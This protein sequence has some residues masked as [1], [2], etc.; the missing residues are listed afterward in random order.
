[1]SSWHKVG[2]VLGL[3]CDLDAGTMQVTVDGSF[4]GRNGGTPFKKGVHPGPKVGSGLFPAVTGGKCQIKCN[5]G[6]DLLRN[7]FRFSAPSTDYI[8]LSI[9]A[10]SLLTQGKVSVLRSVCNGYRSRP[11]ICLNMLFLKC[12]K[13]AC[14]S[15]LRIPT[16]LSHS[17]AWSLSL[18]AVPC[19]SLAFSVSSKQSELWFLCCGF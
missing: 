17:R 1:M 13:S 16:L 19:Y 18:N 10:N 6:N 14:R 4:S 7:P 8:A 11:Y 3:A 12:T 9:S 2:S 5:L 15:M